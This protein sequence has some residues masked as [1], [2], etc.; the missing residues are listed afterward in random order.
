MNDMPGGSSMP[1]GGGGGGGGGG[2][3]RRR[4]RRGGRNRGRGFGGGGGG[5]G[6]GGGG[7]G[8]GNGYG[9]PP[10][11]ADG[12]GPAPSFDGD[13]N[14]APPWGAPPR[15]PEETPP[16]PE[17]PFVKP[18]TAELYKLPVLELMREG[19]GFLRNPGNGYYPTPDDAYVP[20]QLV[21]LYGM[22]DGVIVDG[23]IGPPKRPGQNPQLLSVRSLGGIAPH[24][25][26]TAGAWDTL[27]VVDPD[28]KIDLT[29]GANDTTARIIDLMC[30][31][32]FGQ[33]SLITS[34]P[35][36]G[37]T[38]ILQKIAQAIMRNHP[39]VYLLVLLVDERPE[40]ATAMTRAVSGEVAVSTNDRPPESHARLT[41][42]VLKKA[43]RLVETGHD[44]VILMDS[45]TRLGR[46][47]NLLQRGGGRTL[48]G[49]MDSRSLERPKAFFAGARNVEHGGSLTII[50]TALIDT[51]SKMD[52]LIFEEFKGTGNMELVLDRNAAEQR[53]WPAIDVNKSGT[54]KEEKLLPPST[55][56]KLYVLRR[57]LNKVHPVEALQL[58][59]E[60]IEKTASNDEF[61]KSISKARATAD[62]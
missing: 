53:I 54:R 43:K 29:G 32:G 9:G 17:T 56:E 27:T 55:L 50:A 21:R 18:T 14:A 26:R 25:Y 60:R 8:G 3:G 57:V 20:V 28:R 19:H 30:P 52:Q 46:A 59:V 4:R 42:V 16:V 41:E 1:M 44:V 38:I 34:P 11:E 61:L 48:S 12:F 22:R 7:G 13:P 39:D 33:R 5:G 62:D 6:Y 45:L 40:E 23:E 10:M 15:A 49:G 47:Y 35:R 36:A 24:L 51:G 2:R 37:K 31:I 58:L